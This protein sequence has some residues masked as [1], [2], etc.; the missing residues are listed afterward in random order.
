ML[1][2]VVLLDIFEETVIDFD[3]QSSKEQNL[4]EI[5][6]FCNICVITVTFNN[7]ND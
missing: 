4:F 7:F 3:E 5:K 1:K 2:T 6:I